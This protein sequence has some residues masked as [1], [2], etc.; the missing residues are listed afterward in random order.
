M[1]NLKYVAL[2]KIHCEVERLAWNKI[3]P[4]TICNSQ[5]LLNTELSISFIYSLSYKCPS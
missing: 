5:L 4:N 1:N 2:D 3:A